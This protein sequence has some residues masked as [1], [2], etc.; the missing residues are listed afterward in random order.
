M[1]AQDRAKVA[2]AFVPVMLEG[3]DRLANYSL[4]TF[5]CHHLHMRV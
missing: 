1:Q 3:N 5:S 2:T 4:L